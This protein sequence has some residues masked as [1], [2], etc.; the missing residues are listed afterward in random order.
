MKMFVK[1]V[2][3]VRIVSSG[4]REWRMVWVNYWGCIV[5][6]VFGIVCIKY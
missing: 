1:V 4:S 2:R 5:F 6:W 3:R